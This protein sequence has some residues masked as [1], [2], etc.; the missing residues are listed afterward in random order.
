MSRQQ[1]PCPHT[2]GATVRVT[3]GQACETGQGGHHVGAAVV[4]QIGQSSIVGLE[5]DQD[6]RGDRMG[7]GA[8]DRAFAPAG[9]LC[10]EVLTERLHAVKQIT[11]LG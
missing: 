2:A 6:L 10:Y 4:R 9:N 8:P 7:Q 1:R 5:P 3:V 11:T